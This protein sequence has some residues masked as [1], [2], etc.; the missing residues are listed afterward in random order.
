MAGA[1]HHD[2]E[3]LNPLWGDDWRSVRDLFDLEP[4]HSHLN[5]GSYRAAP[6]PGLPVQWGVRRLRCAPAGGADGGRA[7]ALGPGPDGPRLAVIDHIASATARLFPVERITPA[8]RD[9][10]VAVF[11]DAA[12]SPGMMPVDLEALAPDFWVGNLHKW[13]YAPIGVAALYVAAERRSAMRP[14][15]VSVRGPAGY[16]HSYLQ[17]GTADLAA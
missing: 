2:T 4:R 5:H 10:G 9:R 8:L 7:A 13:A 12:H 14:L 11:I 1:E 15:V 3:A 16:P 6:L 17:A